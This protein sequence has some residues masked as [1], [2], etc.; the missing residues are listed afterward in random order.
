MPRLFF[1]FD[2]ARNHFRDGEGVDL[3]TV[4]T[5]QD[6]VLRTLAD[7]VREELPKGDQQTFTAHV[8]DAAGN[9]VYTARVSVTGTWHKS[10]PV[11]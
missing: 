2:D 11:A 7:V 6:E 9:S 4:E 5:A 8:R 3:P 1:D 10:R